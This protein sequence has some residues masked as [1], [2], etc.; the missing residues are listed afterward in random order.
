MKVPKLFLMIVSHL[1]GFL[2]FENIFYMNWTSS[3]FHLAIM[4]H[5]V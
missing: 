4:T 2:K 1:P 3:L 5:V